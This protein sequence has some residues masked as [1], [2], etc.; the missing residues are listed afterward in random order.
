MLFCG[1]LTALQVTQFLDNG[2]TAQREA[3]A[4]I[5]AIEARNAELEAV[6]ERQAAKIEEMLQV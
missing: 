1:P 5:R 2:N 3:D 6:A 4:K